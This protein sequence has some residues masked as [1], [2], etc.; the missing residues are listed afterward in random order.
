[1]SQREV[2]DNKA[3]ENFASAVV[4]CLATRPPFR[5]AAKK[6]EMLSVAADRA[7]RVDHL[8]DRAGWRRVEAGRFT[9]RCSVRPT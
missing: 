4:P 1:M 6:T 3:L 9:R 8:P 7:D 2:T 5:M